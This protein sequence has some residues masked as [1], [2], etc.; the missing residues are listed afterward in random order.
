MNTYYD[1]VYDLELQLITCIEDQLTAIGQPLPCISC[2][3][4][5]EIVW[6]ECNNGGQL[7]LSTQDMYYSTVFPID[8]SQDVVISTVCGPGIATATIIAS[9]M[10]CAP[11][12]TGNPPRPPTCQQL[13]E[14][15]IG[16]GR[17]SYAMRTGI[18]CCLTSMRKN[19]EII[20]FRM[21][22]TT[23]A[24][25]EGGCVGNIMTLYVGFIEA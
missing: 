1:N 2:I 17:D 9:L 10:R 24:G 19:Y 13:S 14:T 8:N 20:D 22:R 25:P 6:D 7:I 4:P 3:V 5:G 21:G 16:I 18:L 15:S 23:V 12:V 11:K